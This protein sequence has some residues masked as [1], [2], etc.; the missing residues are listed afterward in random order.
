MCSCSGWFFI[1]LF[2]FFCMVLAWL[3]IT[4]AFVF[5]ILHTVI[6]LSMCTAVHVDI[7]IYTLCEDYILVLICWY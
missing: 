2:L 7:F 4:F 6:C 3:G 1:T 5:F